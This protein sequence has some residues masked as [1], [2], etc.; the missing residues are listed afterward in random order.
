MSHSQTTPASNKGVSVMEFR[1]EEALL[2]HLIDDIESIPSDPSLEQLCSKAKTSISKTPF[3]ILSAPDEDHTKSNSVEDEF[4]RLQTLKSYNVLD[5]MFDEDLDRLTAMASRMFDVPIALVSL[6][7]LGRIWCISNRG[8]GEVRQI[9]R[10]DSFCAHA[11]LSNSKS[12]IV[13]DASKDSRFSTNP[14]V[15]EGG[16]RFYGGAPLETPENY[17]IGNFCLLGTK[18]RPE[19]LSEAELMTLVDFAAMAVKVLVDRR[20]RR[21][22]EIKQDL[23]VAHTA[24][25]LI[26]PLTGLQMSLNLL[27]EDVSLTSRMDDEQQE[28]LS[29]AIVCTDIMS[30][31][32]HVTL[33]DLKKVDPP[34]VTMT[35]E[36]S[37]S[38]SN[39]HVKDLFRCLHQ[40]IAPLSKKVPIVFSMETSLMNLVACDGLALFRFAL[41][42]LSAACDRTKRGSISL[43]LFTLKEESTIAIECED[44]ATSLLAKDV[45]LL[46]DNSPDVCG[47]TD[48]ALGGIQFAIS[49]AHSIGSS[50][51]VRGRSLVD[52]Q[53]DS[54]SV[55]GS[56][57]WF[58]LPASFDGDY[59]NENSEITGEVAS[60]SACHEVAT[61]TPNSDC[62]FQSDL[63][64]TMNLLEPKE[65]TLPLTG[66]ELPCSPKEDSL[67][68]FWD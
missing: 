58:H 50:C 64:Q 22:T 12:F 30:R 65:N 9:P 1:T 44:T 39:C 36:C 68:F 7:D 57:F 11:V 48:P 60:R 43:R 24:H 4:R 42:L 63:T 41:S 28:L 37:L 20:Y 38:H 26:T 45:N 17:R 66:T 27:N 49:L 67:D 34:A 10:K 5:E 35:S 56:V 62:F 33:A 13:P 29:T 6:V 23:I 8:L 25:D 46:F 21:D 61:G 47:L 3:W 14:L 51:G 15:T 31:F 19:G 55:D 32:C 59:W 40:T 16:I 53:Q 18:P 52:D 54:D 2:K